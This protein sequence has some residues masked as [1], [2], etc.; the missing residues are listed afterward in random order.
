MA[1]LLFSQLEGLVIDWVS[2]NREGLVDSK[3]M[4]GRLSKYFIWHA[5]IDNE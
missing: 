2:V 5:L 4:A 1:N 3:T